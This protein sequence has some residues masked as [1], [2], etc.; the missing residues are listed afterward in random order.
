[1]FDAA[2]ELPTLLSALA[3]LDRVWLPSL[4][5][6]AGSAEPG[7]TGRGGAGIPASGG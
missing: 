5:L 1:M 7:D 6:S 3:E 2:P 4:T